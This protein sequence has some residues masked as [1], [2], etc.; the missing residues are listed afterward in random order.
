MNSVDNQFYPFLLSKNSF[1]V[2]VTNGKEPTV[3]T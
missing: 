2:S 3:E 1:E